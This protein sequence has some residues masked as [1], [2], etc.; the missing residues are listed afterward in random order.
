[1]LHDGRVIEYTIVPLEH[2]D[3]I[4]REQVHEATANEIALAI[5]EQE[6]R[7]MQLHFLPPQMYLDPSVY[8]GVPADQL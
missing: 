4:T 8:E 6:D 7:R 5:Q 3:N 1:M 2:D